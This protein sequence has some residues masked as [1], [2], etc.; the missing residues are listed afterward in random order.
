MARL[1]PLDPASLTPEQQKIIAIRPD[2]LHHG[3]H[4]VW[5]RRPKLASMANEM[6][7]YL[8]SGGVEIEPRLAELTILIIA[9]AYTAQFAWAAHEPQALKAGIDPAIVDAIRHRRE[10]RFINADEAMIYTF[11]NEL[12]ET[13][14]LNDAT[15][16]LA[17]GL[18]GEPFVI[19][20]VALIGCY[21]MIG[22]NLIAFQVDPTEGVKLLE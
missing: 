13:R 17:K 16:A 18:W 3:P 20:L 19:D 7:R 10:P 9:R 21:T 5:L 12:I 6:M 14:T 4:T 22:T 11:T 1:A 15:Y 8:R 2:R